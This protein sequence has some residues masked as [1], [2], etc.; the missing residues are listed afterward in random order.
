MFSQASQSEARTQERI[1][2]LNAGRFL[3]RK[4]ACG[5]SSSL[6]ESCTECNKQRLPRNVNAATS[7]RPASHDFSRVRVNQPD[8]KKALTRSTQ[9]HQ[10]GAE[11]DEH[12]E[13][14][15]PEGAL[16]MFQSGTCI[17]GGAGSTC[18]FD[19]GVF[20]MDNNDNT[21]CTKGCTAAHEA[22]HKRDIDGWGCCAA[23]STAFN[24]KGAD[25]AK[26]AKTYNDWQNKVVAITECNAY[27]NDVTCADALAKAKDCSGAGKGT[28]CC[29][30][31]E[32][33]KT[34]YGALAKTNC[35]AAPKKAEPC[36][37]F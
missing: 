15:S 16:V 18:H 4:C 24:A 27:S 17:N 1:N 32:D 6:A 23:A 21:C 12:A 31:I 28:D 33:Y 36:P 35:A 11:Q 8:Q 5:G 30:D 3:Q 37:K 7:S 14:Y 20:K 9:L 34:R 13:E 19:T 10:L 22:V 25:K 29:K 2:A 26:V